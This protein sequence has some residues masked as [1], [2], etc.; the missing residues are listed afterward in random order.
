MATRLARRL[1]QRSCGAN[2]G[3][4]NAAVKREND[5]DEDV[6][7]AGTVEDAAAAAIAAQPTGFTLAT[8]NVQTEVTLS[9]ICS[10]AAI[11]QSARGS[12][13]QKLADSSCML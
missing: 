3:V 13:V 7:Q 5:D 9:F 8:T 6:E 10:V 2:S 12:H 4:H 1:H 11:L